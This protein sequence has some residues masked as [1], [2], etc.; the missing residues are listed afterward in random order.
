MI[1]IGSRVKYI[2]KDTEDAK[3]TGYYPPIGTYGTVTYTDEDNTIEVKWDKGTDGDQIWWCE[4]ED[5]EEVA[6]S[7]MTKLKWFF[8]SGRKKLLYQIECAKANKQILHLSNG[9]VLDFTEESEAT[10]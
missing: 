1:E 3:A 7:K 9:I 4:R 8:M 2:R 10:K 6:S 5:V